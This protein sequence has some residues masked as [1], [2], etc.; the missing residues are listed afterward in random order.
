MTSFRGEH[1]LVL[2]KWTMLCVLA[3]SRTY[4]MTGASLLISRRGYA[5]T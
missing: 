5:G 1:L 2:P 4:V 3:C